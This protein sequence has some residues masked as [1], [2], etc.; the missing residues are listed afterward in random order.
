M[1]K[2]FISFI[3]IINVLLS[4]IFAQTTTATSVIDWNSKKFTSQLL[5]DLN[6]SGFSMPSG[7]NAAVNKI[8]QQLPELVKSPL[9]NIPVDDTNLLGNIILQNIVSLADLTNIVEQSDSNPGIY[10]GNTDSISLENN[11]KLQDIA[12]LMVK[13]HTPYEVHIPIE[14]V[15]SREFSGIIIDMRG[16]LP[17]HGEFIEDTAIPCFFP[18]I[19]DEK[20]NLIYEKN[21][22][23]PSIAKKNGIVQYTYSLDEKDYEERIGLKPLRITAREIFGVY[24]TDP[25]ISHNDALKILSKKE[26]LDL[27]KQ[28]KIVFLM[29]ED[30]LTYKASAPL[31]DEPYY[32]AYKELTNKFSDLKIKSVEVSDSTQGLLISIRDLKFI[33][34]TANLLPEES[35]RLDTIATALM[36]IT[37]D[38]ENTILVAGHTASVG[39][40]QGE[41]DLS[42]KRAQTI[43]AELVKRG[44]PRELFTYQGFGG[45]VPIGDNSTA[46]GR[47]ANRR[48]EITIVPKAT[49]IQRSSN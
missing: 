47:A 4:T 17:V 1:A 31:K 6:D 8:K 9:L 11:I 16:F 34:D 7:R 18:K 42:I 23:D 39:K 32:F 24:R 20:M 45:T 33:A 41:K 2:H 25:V 15:P 36:D 35:D 19:Y 40:P 10:S 28:G 29:N 22:T 3:F 13:H 26:N 44:V 12:A 43:I 14:K 27:I 38:S 37:T 30:A 21:M 46:E 5:L 48:V 49:Y